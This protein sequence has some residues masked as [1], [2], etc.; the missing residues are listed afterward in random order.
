[1]SWSTEQVQM[2]IDHYRSTPL[3][4][5]VKHPDYF[6]KC[7][8]SQAINNLILQLNRP[9]TTENDVKAKWNSLKTT[10]MAEKRKVLACASSGAGEDEMY[11]PKLWYYSQLYFLDDHVT[12]R[13]SKSNIQLEGLSSELQVH[14]GTEEEFVINEDGSLSPVPSTSSSSTSSNRV[15]TSSNQNTNCEITSAKKK[16]TDSRPRCNSCNICTRN[17]E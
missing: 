7:K 2:I 13:K 8:R 11:K 10:Y 14:I 16:K 1:M 4:F 9:G 12:P 15:L 17:I 5:M 6:N 3:L